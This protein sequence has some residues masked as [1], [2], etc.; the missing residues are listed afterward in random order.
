MYFAEER[1]NSKALRKKLQGKKV[2]FFSFFSIRP[3]YREDLKSILDYAVTHNDLSI[4]KDI[5]A[6]KPLLESKSIKKDYFPKL[7]IGGAYSRLD[8]RS[9]QR[10]G[11]V[12]NGYVKI[13]FNLFDGN[14]KRFS[15]K[16]K[17]FEYQALNFQ[18]NTKPQRI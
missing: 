4:A 9:M 1:R 2:F 18:S 6:K 10:P 7:F 5:N 8:P 13:S 3:P 11:D 15:L 14:K 12:Y 17:N 16:S